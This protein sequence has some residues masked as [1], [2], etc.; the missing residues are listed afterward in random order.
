MQGAASQ[1]CPCHST[2]MHAAQIG[3]QN[4]PPKWAAKT[5]RQNRPSK[6]A[7]KTAR[8]NRPPKEAIKKGRQNRPPKKAAT[9][10]HHVTIGDEMRPGQFLHRIS[11]P[12]GDAF[13]DS[14]EPPK[15]ATKKGRQNSPPKKA[16]KIG[17]QNTP[18]NQAALGL[19]GVCEH[20][21]LPFPLYQSLSSQVFF[22]FYRRAP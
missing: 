11:A 20:A 12:A 19:P 3:H 8:Q 18:T 14:I 5:G 17:C 7:A 22:F 1:V 10:G 9:I 4:R 6:Q 16:T 2:R 21:A 13:D 15:Q